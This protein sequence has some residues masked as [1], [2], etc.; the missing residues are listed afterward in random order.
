MTNTI[1]CTL[2]SIE[3]TLPNEIMA[4]TS[5]S[6]GVPDTTYGFIGIGN[7]GFGMAK[8]VRAKIPKSSK[9]I[10]CELNQARRKEFV[11]SVEGVLETADS[12]KELADKAVSQ[13]SLDH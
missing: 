11:S 10:I 1:V 9:L 13:M 12:P 3:K 7:M 4:L 8:N 6:N 5:T 2:H